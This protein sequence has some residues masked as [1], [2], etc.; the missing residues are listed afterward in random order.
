V[1]GIVRSAASIAVPAALWIAAVTL[2]TGDYR[3]RTALLLNGFTGADTWTDDWQ[4]WFLEALVWGYLG[5]ALMLAVPWL[6]RLS[7]RSSFGLAAAVLGGAL[8]LRFI[9]VGVEAGPVERY[10]TPVVLW[11]LALGW[12]AAQADTTRRRALVAVAAV[13]STLGFFGDTQREVIVA[14]GVVLLLVDRAVAV[15]RLMSGAVQA[16]AAASLWI[17]LTQWQVYPAIEDAGHPYE[18]VLAAVAVGIAVHAAYERVSP[19]VLGRWSGR[20]RRHTA[21]VA[22]PVAARADRAAAG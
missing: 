20:S 4:F 1:R 8:A 16:V 12:A 2:V 10:E 19:T 17:Y 21:S 7:Q 22:S 14:V 13:A 15:P 3:W 18:A 5:V 6:H 11:C 9:L